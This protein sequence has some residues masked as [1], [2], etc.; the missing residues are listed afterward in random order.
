MRPPVTLRAYR[1]DEIE[2]ALDRVGE[3]DRRTREQRRERLRSSGRR[4]FTE[5]LFAVEA[6]D[7][8][9]GEVQARFDGN[10]MPPG[11]FEIGIEIWEESDR[12]RGLGSAALAALLE[13]LFT[14]EG[15]ERVQ[16]STDLDNAAMRRTFE[17][18]GFA[19]E[20]I[21]RGFM[22]ADDGRHD[23]ASYAITRTDR[24]GRT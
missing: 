16:G 19:F 10:L 21:L 8:L 18:L 12:G 9:V 17:S 11:V 6:E 15:A 7:R 22:P 13:H 2:R 20:G 4:Y 5:L 1:E 14:S 3:L 24:E 23:Y